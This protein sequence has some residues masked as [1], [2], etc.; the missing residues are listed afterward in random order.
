MASRKHSHRRAR[1]QGPK[2]VKPDAVHDAAL[3]ALSENDRVWF[4]AHPEV[5]VRHR[6]LR[7][8]ELCSPEL[9]P[10]CVSRLKLPAD[11]PIGD[12]RWIVRVTQIKPGLR[13]REFL[14]GGNMEIDEDGTFMV[15]DDVLEFE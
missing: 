8:H 4:E 15:P 9:W 2:K 11:L 5:S 13:Q 3:D 6:V 14:V 12:V 1:S 7:P 10:D